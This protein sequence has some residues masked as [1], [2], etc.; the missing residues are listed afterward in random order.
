MQFPGCPHFLTPPVVLEV[1]ECKAQDRSRQSLR[2]F[3]LADCRLIDVSQME[4]VLGKD[5]LEGFAVAAIFTIDRSFHNHPRCRFARG[6]RNLHMHV[7]I[8]ADEP[9]ILQVCVC[10]VIQREFLTG[11]R[12]GVGGVWTQ[13]PSQD[14]GYSDLRWRPTG[15][16]YVLL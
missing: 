12:R 5:A 8:E 9:G 15:Q 14:L 10:N 1:A 6:V 16:W 13:R 2:Q 7:A 3:G 11:S 4:V